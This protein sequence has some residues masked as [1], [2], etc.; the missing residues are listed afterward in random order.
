MDNIMQLSQEF[1]GFYVAPYGTVWKETYGLAM[2][3]F[4]E[5]SALQSLDEYSFNVY[6]KSGES[7]GNDCAG[8]LQEINFITYP[9][10][11]LPWDRNIK[12]CMT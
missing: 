1:H 11:V 7:L 9:I 8:I 12:E 10:Y 3:D 2:S 5:K 6:R 4:Q